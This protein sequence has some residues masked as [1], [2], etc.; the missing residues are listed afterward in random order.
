VAL[1]DAL[2]VL[3]PP[4]GGPGFGSGAAGTGW[5]KAS[6]APRTPAVRPDTDAC[7]RLRESLR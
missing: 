4:I 2:A 6:S 1:I 7:D 5:G 3:A